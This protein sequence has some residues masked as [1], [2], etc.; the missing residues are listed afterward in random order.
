[1]QRPGYHQGSPRCI[2]QLGIKSV[3]PARR[4]SGAA[5]TL[6]PS[7]RILSQKHN[8]TFF[9]PLSTQPALPCF[10][11]IAAPRSAYVP[12][13]RDIP[14]SCFSQTHAS[15]FSRVCTRLSLHQIRT[16]DLH[17]WLMLG[18]WLPT[19]RLIARRTQIDGS[20]VDQDLRILM[21]CS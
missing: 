21:I 11:G 13:S 18:A 20:M 16:R 6:Q 10:T 1:M 4:H 7:S 14:C 19:T 12:K 9:N 8:L 2:L 3:T 15:C 17:R 5:R